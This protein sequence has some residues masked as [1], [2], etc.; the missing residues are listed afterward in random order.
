MCARAMAFQPKCLKTGW[1]FSHEFEPVVESNCKA[2]RQARKDRFVEYLCDK[3]QVLV[4]GDVL[5]IA[6][7]DSRALL[8]SMLEGEE[9]EVGETGSLDVLS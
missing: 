4:H 3:P 7:R 1:E 5:A 9:S 2:S 8:A 6:H